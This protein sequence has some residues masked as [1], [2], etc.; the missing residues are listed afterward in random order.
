MPNVVVAV[1]FSSASL[2]LLFLSQQSCNSDWVL[3]TVFPCTRRQL[4]ICKSSYHHQ[5][6]VV[7]NEDALQAHYTTNFWKCHF[8]FRSGNYFFTQGKLETMLLGLMHE[9]PNF[10]SVIGHLRSSK[11]PNYFWMV[12]PCGDSWGILLACWGILRLSFDHLGSTTKRSCYELR[13][14]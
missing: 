9:V 8:L 13:A 12:V 3:D 4:H 1:S 10:T 6:T 5:R 11:Q 7:G 14:L 2:S